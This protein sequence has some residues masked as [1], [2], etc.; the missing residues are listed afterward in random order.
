MNIFGFRPFKGRFNLGN[1]DDIPTNPDGTLIGAVKRKIG[2]ESGTVGS[3][4]TQT[5]EKISYDNTNE[6][7]ILKVNGADT[8]VPFKKG[9]NEKQ[10]AYIQGSDRSHAQ[11][12]LD[13]DTNVI[14]YCGSYP[15][16]STVMGI[17]VNGVNM[18]NYATTIMSSNYGSY[19]YG[20]YFVSI[21]RNCKKG[22]VVMLTTTQ[23]A[24]SMC[25]VAYA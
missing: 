1:S 24:T 22:D 7:L 12:T 18:D 6:Q 10:I 14:Y 21:S 13:H 5:V 2:T 20:L 9:G 23:T 4:T 8:P 16:T 17:T 3:Y 25:A 19:Q 15:F 11:I